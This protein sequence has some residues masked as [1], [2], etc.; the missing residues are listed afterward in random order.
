M[1]RVP[2]PVALNSVSVSGAVA[3]PPKVP[4]EPLAVPTHSCQAEKY[5]ISRGFCP[6]EI[7]RSSPA[8]PRKTPSITPLL[9]GLTQ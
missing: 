6:L 9:L 5:G 3:K 1:S 2:D 4:L 7:P 8:S